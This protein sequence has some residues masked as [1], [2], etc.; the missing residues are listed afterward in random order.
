M[1]T[2]AKV[3]MP[4]RSMKAFSVFEVPFFFII[5]SNFSNFNF[6]WFLVEEPQKEA[7]KTVLKKWYHL[8]CILEK[9]GHILKKSKK[10]SKKTSIFS[11]K[12]Q[13]LNVLRIVIFPIAFYCQ[14]ATNWW[15]N[16]TLRTSQHR[17]SA[18]SISKHQVKKRTYLRGSFAFTLSRIWRK[19]IIQTNKTSTTNL[20]ALRKSAS[21]TCFL[22]NNPWWHRGP[23]SSSFPKRSSNLP[24]IPPFSTPLYRIPEPSRVQSKSLR[25]LSKNC[26]S[27]F[28]SNPI[29]SFI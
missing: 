4:F 25:N 17:F 7:E 3:L 12:T 28:P 8:T 9:I 15:K 24:T 19:I 14:F 18:I 29:V 22:H 1:R 6:F 26:D 16:S 13:N 20:T 10:I 2:L 21:P 11:I 23:K 5:N 27:T